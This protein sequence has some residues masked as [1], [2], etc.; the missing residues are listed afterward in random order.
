MVAAVD[1]LHPQPELGRGALGDRQA[2]EPRSDDDEVGHRTP[3]APMTSLGVPTQRSAV[4]GIA[5]VDE[6]ADARDIRRRQLGVVGVVGLHDREVGG[7]ADVV[8]RQAEALELVVGVQRI[9]HG[10]LR[11]ARLQRLDRRRT[12]PRT[13]SP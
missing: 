4:G 11:T 2:E 8:R 13:P 9:V 1:D 12:R 10:D 3:P 6:Q 7:L 5:T